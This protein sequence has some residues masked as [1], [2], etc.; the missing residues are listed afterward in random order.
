M[1]D[2]HAKGLFATFKFKACDCQWLENDKL[3][4]FFPFRFNI[5]MEFCVFF[6]WRHVNL[7]NKGMIY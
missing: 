4:H 2:T 3:C 5:E 1:Q 7:H 6:M